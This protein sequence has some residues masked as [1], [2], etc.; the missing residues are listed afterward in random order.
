M[1][2]NVSEDRTLDHVAGYATFNDVSGRR[3]SIDVP[4]Q[5]TAR[6]GYFDWLKG[7]WFDTFGPLGPYLAIDE[8]PDPQNLTFKRA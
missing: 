2:R 8:I 3:R 6:T 4:R 1:A 7:K 5:E